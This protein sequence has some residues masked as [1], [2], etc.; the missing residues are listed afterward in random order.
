MVN[1]LK[2]II[3]LHFLICKITEFL[4][5]CHQ[6]VILNVQMAITKDIYVQLK[7]WH[8]RGDDTLSK[9]M[10]TWLHQ[11]A[12]MSSLGPV[13]L[14][15]QTIYNISSQYKCWSAHLIHLTNIFWKHNACLIMTYLN[16]WHLRVSDSV[17]NPITIPGIAHVHPWWYASEQVIVGNCDIDENTLK[18]ILFIIK[19]F[20][21]LSWKLVLDVF[22]VLCD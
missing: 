17:Q 12:S 7:A 14:A 15:Q 18:L 6:N 20:P 13:L 10:K 16:N 8:P 21:G 5:H 1:I 22:V 4:F 3:P 9:I 19:T 11:Q 2:I